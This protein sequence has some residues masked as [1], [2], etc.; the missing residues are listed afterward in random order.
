MAKLKITGKELL[1]WGFA[2]GKVMGVALRVV[3]KEYKHS[4]LE[5]VRAALTEVLVTP[6][7]FIEDEVLGPIAQLLMPEPEDLNPEIPLREF[8]VPYTIYGKENIEKGAI[9]QMEIAVKLPVAV[10]GSIMPDSHQGYGLPIGGVLAVKN[11]VIPYGVGV[12]IGC[13][14]CLTIYDEKASYIDGNRLKLKNALINNTFF[15]T[16]VENN[17]PF[18]HELLDRKEFSEIPSI[19]S[20]KDKAWRQLGTSGS[21]N[22]F[23]DIGIVKITDQTNDFGLDIGEYVGILTHSGSRG[24]GATLADKYTKIAMEKTRLP[25]EAKHLAWLDLNSEEGME[26]WIAMNIAGD[27]A[28]ACHDEIHR[29]IAKELNLRP[30]AKIENHHNFAWKE[31]VNG[32][33]VVV[34]RKGAT[35]AGKGVLGIIPGSMVSPGFIVRGKG[36]EDSISSSSH[37]AG[38]TMSRTKAKA[39]FTKSDVNKILKNHKVDLIGGGL[40]ESPFAYKDINEVIKAQES[41]IDILGTFT[42]QIVRMAD[43]NEERKW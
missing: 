32:E 34:H 1:E 4:S 2:P 11:A 7:I 42:P 24:F 15:G 43:E 19:K 3:N 23:S 31:M 36:V 26:Y 5:D 18:D 12:D 13:R 28:Q 8:G 22:H 30:I 16:G 39:L 37:G 6:E 21:G 35:P 27:Y 10:A 20:L 17:K 14:M 33:E 41:L 9:D 25:S 38:R 29:R 40:D